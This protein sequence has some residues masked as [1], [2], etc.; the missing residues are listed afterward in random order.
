MNLENYKYRMGLLKNEFDTK[1]KGKYKIP[2][3]P[4]ADLSDKDFENLLLIGF[5]RTNKQ[6]DLDRIVHFFLYDYKFERVWK[7]PEGCIERLKNYKAV[8]SPDFSMYIQMNPVIKLYNT[9]RNRYCGAYFA[10]KGLKVI[11]SVNWGNED[12]FDFC[13]EG[14]PKGST[15]AV[16][17]YQVSEHG[18]HA[19]QK[20]FFMKGYNEMLKRIEPERIICYHEPFDE[21]N[22]NIVYVNYEQSSW[23][24]QQKDFELSEYAEY[25]CG[26]KPLPENSD[27]IIKSGFVLPRTYEKG[28]G[29]A[30]GG[31]WIPKKEDDKRLLGNPGEIKTT[32]MQSGAKYITRIGDDGRA[33]FERH[34]TDHGNPKF[35]SNPHDHIIDWHN[36]VEGIPNFIRKI[37][38]WDGN[39]PEIDDKGEKTNVNKDKDNLNFET[40]SELLASL[41]KADKVTTYYCS[42]ESDLSFETLDEFVQVVLRGG[43]VTFIYKGVEYGI[44]FCDDG[45]SVSAL[46]SEE[47]EKIYKT[48]KETLDYP[49]GNVTIRDI[50]TTK[51]V[52]IT[53]RNI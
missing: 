3:I 43:E 9:F 53:N 33:V 6:K 45:I 47:S 40:V 10:S 29:D 7:D 38:Y 41:P 19:D 20:D 46:N 24:Y 36:P 27:I 37:N 50:I 49:I 16:S 32:Y 15:V 14:I 52:E 48:A 31:K 28:T 4:K 2:E 34:C 5:D 13:F 8:L 39:V 21:M 42:G 26:Q 44:F 51:E 12:T 18:N 30:H 25:I 17:T 1:S 22:G 11:P 35:H 23:K